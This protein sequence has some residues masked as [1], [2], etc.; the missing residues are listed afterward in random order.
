VPPEVKPGYTNTFGMRSHPGF[1][2]RF[3]NEKV[4]HFGTVKAHRAYICVTLD[5]TQGG[6]Q[7]QL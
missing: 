2:I 1:I 5:E 3:G 6:G 4:I 7:H